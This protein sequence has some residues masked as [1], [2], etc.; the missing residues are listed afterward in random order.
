[1]T[2]TE[3]KSNVS[4][5]KECDA[6]AKMAV[7]AFDHVMDYVKNEDLRRLLAESRRDHTQLGDKL[8]EKLLRC[9][10]DDEEPPA[11]GKIGA[12]VST[13]VKLM[14]DDSD[15][16]IAKIV[17]EGCHMGINS[18]SHYMNSYQDADKESYDLCTELIKMEQTL[19]D[20]LR[21][22]L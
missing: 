20:D 1:M 17:S 12:W 13:E 22:Y 2:E 19:M 14:M 18:L 3:R 11:M 8:H 7:Y 15:S 9:R 5:L 6:G 4:L 21:L 10:S 16:K